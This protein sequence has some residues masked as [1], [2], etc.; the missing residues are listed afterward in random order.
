M[1]IIFITYGNQ[2]FSKSLHRIKREAKKLH[3]FDKI[4]LYTPKDLPSYITSSPLFAFE[5]LGGYAIW[6]SYVIYET[7]KRCNYGDI[8][9]YADAGCTL[10]E[11]DEWHHFFNLLTPG[12][13][14]LFQ[15]RTNVDY[16]WTQAFGEHA[17]VTSQNWIKKSVQDY[18]APF[19]ESTDWLTCNKLWNGACLVRKGQNT[20][21]LL[22]D[23]HNLTFIKPELSYDPF[24]FESDSQL[25]EFV[26]HRHDQALIGILAAFYKN[27][28]TIH[29]VPETAEST[30]NTAA[31]AATRI[32]NL[33]PVSSFQRINKCIKKILG[34]QNWNKF[35]RNR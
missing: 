22:E 6:K 23:W 33:P 10:Q 24:G 2:N 32:K 17:N 30:P 12:D 11:S 35:K 8:I 27:K 16:Q 26:Q 1:A 31:I 7:Y 13:T 25:P 9:V 34:I 19:F 14:L 21:R 18:F 4:I 15:Y 5:R 3:F 28:Q 20:N 29:F